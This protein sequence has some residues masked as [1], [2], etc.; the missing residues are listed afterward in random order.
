MHFLEEKD[1]NMSEIFQEMIGTT[2]S[3]VK[4]LDVSD[5]D[6]LHFIDTK[7]NLYRFYHQ[8]DCCE[9]VYIE[10]ICGDLDDLVGSPILVAQGYSNHPDNDEDISST[11]TFYTFR[12]VKGTVSV[13]W[14]GS[15]NGYYSESVNY[16]F[17][18]AR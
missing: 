9:G 4:R 17:V 12:T 18:Q 10:D 1:K 7:G 14:Y 16:E 2:M 3:S 5:G 13:R 8:Q 6:E 11:W 15:S